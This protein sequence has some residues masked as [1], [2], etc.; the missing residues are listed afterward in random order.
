[1]A[2]SQSCEYAN[3]E[4]TILPGRFIGMIKANMEQASNNI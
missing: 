1:M 3:N 4:P 2:F